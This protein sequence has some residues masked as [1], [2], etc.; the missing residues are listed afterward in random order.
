MNYRAIAP[1]GLLALGLLLMACPTG[2][3]QERAYGPMTQGQRGQQEA[4]RHMDRGM[5]QRD[6]RGM[7]DAER[8]RMSPEERRQ[9]RRDIQDAGREIYPP[10]YQGQ[11]RG[12][13][14]RGGRK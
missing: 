14:R 4:Q 11:G 13:Q 6:M 7:G 1:G 5:A 8:G 12:E 3:A 9:L 10:A 2:Y